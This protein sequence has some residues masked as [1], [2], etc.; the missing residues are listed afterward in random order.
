MTNCSFNIGD[1]ALYKGGT[2]VTIYD[3]NKNVQEGESPDIS[4]QMGPGGSIRETV[5]GRLSPYKTPTFPPGVI[6][7]D[8]ETLKQQDEIDYYMDG[9]FSEKERSIL[10]ELNEDTIAE[11]MT[12]EAREYSLPEMSADMDEWEKNTNMKENYHRLIARSPTGGRYED[13]C[14][15]SYRDTGGNKLRKRNQ[16]SD[17]S[18]ELDSMDRLLV[19]AT[20]ENKGHR[21][22]KLSCD[23]G[24]IFCDLKFSRYVPEEGE[25]VK[26][27]AGIRGPC[28]A[29]PLKC[30]RILQ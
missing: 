9:L 5:H 26:C 4:I 30:Y 7:T 18:P 15:P 12:S 27:I 29:L 21:Y 25:K 17:G 1:R 10:K 19:E 14:M 16:V 8:Q 3:I 2:V 20:V 11:I 13:G 23:Y 24:K 22:L 6:L 28:Y